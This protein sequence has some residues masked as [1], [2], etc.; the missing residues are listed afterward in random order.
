VTKR[1]YLISGP[2][3][4]STALMYSFRQRAD[5]TVWDEP[6]YG[7]FLRVTGVE[8]PGGDEVLATTETDGET[9]INDIIFGDYPTPVV[10]FKSMGHHTAGVGLDLSFL[11]R[12]INVFLTRNPADM[13]T[14]FIK[15]VP[16][17][18]A[19]ILGLPQQV[20]LLDAVVAGGGL[21]IV[22]DSKYILMDPP[23]MLGALCERIGI[24]WDPAMLSWPAGPK[25]EDGSWGTY[26]YHNVR[27]STGWQRYRPKND[28]VP[29]RLRGLLEECDGY[30][31]RLMQYAIRTDQERFHQ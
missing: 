28:E 19:D 4:L 9:A 1:I 26:W 13:I 3:N 31:G 29:E 16:N 20:E 2:R 15:N 30:Y 5:T 22:L 18:S 21:P 27:E 14:S 11:E 24:P 8:H 6:L 10:F 7:H 23:A 17:P 12:T 25:P